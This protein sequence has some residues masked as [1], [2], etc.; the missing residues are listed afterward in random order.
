M[1]II[2]DFISSDCVVEFAIAQ[3]GSEMESLA[4]KPLGIT[5]PKKRR[6]AR[7]AKKINKRIMASYYEKRNKK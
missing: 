3:E 7:L 5:M 1:S 2:D 4:W 6:K